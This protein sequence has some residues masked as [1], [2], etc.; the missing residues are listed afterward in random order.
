MNKNEEESKLFEHISK[1][2]SYE[3]PND[4]DEYYME[5]M[6]KLSK[7]KYISNFINLLIL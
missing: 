7:K 3:N 1:M 4:F 6:P 2:A 5:L